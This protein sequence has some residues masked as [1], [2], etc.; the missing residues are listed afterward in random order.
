MVRSPIITTPA[1]APAPAPAL[2]LASAVALLLSAPAHAQ[3]AFF[4]PLGDLPGGPTNSTAWGLSSDGR[5][6]VGGAATAG[7]TLDPIFTAF[8]A[9]LATGTLQPL[10][11][12]PAS[13]IALAA[14]ADGSTIVGVADFGL[15]TPEGT[16]PF[17]WTPAA[18][19][20]LLGDLPG[21]VSG[22]PFAFGRGI[23]A[24]GSVLV[25]IGESDGGIEAWR[26]DRAGANVFQALGSLVTG[27]NFDSRAFGVS[28][29]GSVVVGTSLAGDG[30]FLAFRWT[31]ETGM[32][33]LGFLPTEQGQLPRSEALGISADAEVIVGFSSSL[34]AGTGREAF[35]FADGVMIGLG[36]LPGDPFFSQ[37]L[38]TSADGRMVVGRAT[39]AGACG[40][41]GC[42]GEARAFV[43]TVETGM[44]DLA[45][46]LRAAG[47]TNLT[48]WRLQE[49]R[50]VSADG[51]VV[52]GAGLNP[53]GQPEAWAARLPPIPCR[54]DMNRDAELTFDDLQ[55]FV[56]FFSTN[57]PRADVNLDGEITFD[58]IALFIQLY[59]EGC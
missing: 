4:R 33:P 14:S 13:T 15:G 20:T 45:D 40:P 49:A 32:V 27:E 22:A 2:T 29:D 12:L 25:G 28:A 51:R 48:G 52:V 1:P 19:V 18:G 57:D 16:Q 38:A 36:D 56:L 8:R 6:A 31:A 5:F 9:D 24:D 43:W 11:A 41:F 59:N 17:L 23:S 54:P 34:R 26:L 53:Q 21:G 50:A 39:G 3:P 44:L 35:R 37:A 7:P 10:S 46:V 42:E 55:L 30:V 47:V 58:D